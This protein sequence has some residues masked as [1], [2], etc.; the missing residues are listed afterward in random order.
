MTCC[1]RA[2]QTG[3]EMNPAFETM[4]R[5]GCRRSPFTRGWI[6]WDVRFGGNAEPRVCLER[7]RTGQSAGLA[8]TFRNGPNITGSSSTWVAHFRKI[9]CHS[10][11]LAG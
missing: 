8:P 6:T 3:E 10:V 2:F 11:E 4:N 7:G 1:P 9:H 5:S